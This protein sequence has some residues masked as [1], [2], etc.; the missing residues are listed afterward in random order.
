MCV[1]LWLFVCQLVGF[2][3]FGVVVLLCFFKLKVLLN[4]M[5]QIFP[6]FMQAEDIIK[7]QQLRLSNHL[8]KNPSKDKLLGILLILVFSL[9]QIRNQNEASR[10]Y[11][12][13]GKI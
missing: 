7:K 2:C 12:K 1:C 8:P 10:L 3:G 4:L 5:F 6:K 9:L 13:K 11:Q